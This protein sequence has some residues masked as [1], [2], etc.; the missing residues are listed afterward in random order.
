MSNKIKFIMI[1]LI[2]SNLLWAMDGNEIYRKMQDRDMGE[3]MHAI[4][5]M[6]LIDKN[7]EEKERIIETW[8]M[9]FDRENE[10]SQ[11][12]MEFKAPA[13]VKGTRFLQVQNAGRDDDQWIYLPALGRVRRIAAAEGGS[14]FMGSDF[15]YD[16]MQL[17]GG[18]GEDSE[19]RLLREESFGKWDCYVLE[20]KSLDEDAAYSKLVSWVTK[21]H[22]M[23]VK[24][25]FYKKDSA[26]LLK[27]MTI[28]GDIEEINGVETVFITRMKN[29]QDGHETVLEVMRNKS[30]A[31]FVEYNVE[32]NPKRFTQNYLKTGK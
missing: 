14:S 13:T 16:D 4:M 2:L 30:G 23:P 26:E 27:V 25:E 9:T 12:V 1:G 18:E 11:S 29:V 6:R 24:V 31:P 7:G 3:S 5:K 21:E 32:M 28:E 8:S 10:L 22:F 19:H 15:S 17:Q 20:S